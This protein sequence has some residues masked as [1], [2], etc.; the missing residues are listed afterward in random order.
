M[1]RQFY[2]KPVFK[3]QFSDLM[4]H[5]SACLFFYKINLQLV[6]EHVFIA[7]L[8]NEIYLVHCCQF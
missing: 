8:L 6:V 5:S 7:V 1:S 4:L 3:S 2:L